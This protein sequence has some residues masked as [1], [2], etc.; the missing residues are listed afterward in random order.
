MDAPADLR[1]LP[2]VDRF[3][4]SDAARPLIEAHGRA[5][6]TETLRTL[7]AEIRAG[8]PRPDDLA[9]TI[10]GRLDRAFRRCAR[11]SI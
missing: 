5:R 6:V 8:A 10:A 11:S 7:L 1:S 2:S 9:A 4:R 3:L